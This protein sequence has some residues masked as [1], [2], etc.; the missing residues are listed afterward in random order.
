MWVGALPACMS[1]AHVCAVLHGPEGG[2]GFP[3]TGITVNLAAT[4]LLEI[5][6]WCSGSQ[7]S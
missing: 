3:G 6:T 4:W 5:E 7:S 1:V 2:V